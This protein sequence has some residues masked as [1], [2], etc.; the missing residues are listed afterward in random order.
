MVF[1]IHRH[2]SAMDTHVFPIPIPPSHHPLHPISL[3]LPS[4]PGPSTCLMH[5]TWSGDL[6]TGS[7]TQ[8]FI[9]GRFS[10]AK[11]KEKHRCALI[12]E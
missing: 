6:K 2:E 1:V 5:P 3:G 8:M 9:A 10:I 12:D 11:G 4:V 7:F